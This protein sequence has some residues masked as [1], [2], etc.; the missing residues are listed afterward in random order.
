MSS[1][2][3]GFGCYYCFRSVKFEKV[4]YFSARRFYD[5]MEYLLNRFAISRFFVLDDAFLYSKRRLVEFQEEFHARIEMNPGLS[6]ARLFVMARPETVD[7]EIVDILA[8]LN[9]ICI[10]I[11]LQTVN[12]ALQHYMKRSVDTLH[13]QR[14]RHWMVKHGMKLQLDVVVGLPGDSIEWMK[15]TLRFALLLSPFS[16]QIKQFYLNPNTLF[17]RDCDQYEIEID[18]A[19]S[20]FDAP[21]VV[22]AA[23][24][25]AR[26]FDETNAFIMEQIGAYPEVL[27]KYLSRKKRFLSELFYRRPERATAL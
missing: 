13:F 25:D 21:Y 12:P 23:G 3:C 6:R 14:I 19:P 11:G 17:H 27:W 4:R 7:E 10:Q 26:Y 8:S 2:G 24:I 20:D 18:T 16:L 15:E 1:R 22:K 5:E 9:V